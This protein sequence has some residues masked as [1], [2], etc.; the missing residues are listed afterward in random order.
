[1][2]STA[3][4]ANS[5]TNQ[6]DRGSGGGTVYFDTAARKRRKSVIRAV[7]DDSPMIVSNGNPIAMTR[8]DFPEGEI[9]QRAVAAVSPVAS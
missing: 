8:Y 6:Q 7:R 9:R 5:A 3:N 4:E 1:M 2:N